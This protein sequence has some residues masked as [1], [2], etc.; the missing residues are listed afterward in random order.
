MVSDYHAALRFR[1]SGF[2]SSSGSGAVV[3]KGGNAPEIPPRG[4]F[5]VVVVVTDKE[6]GGNEGR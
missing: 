2:C 6:C 1:G 4:V 5:V 3:K